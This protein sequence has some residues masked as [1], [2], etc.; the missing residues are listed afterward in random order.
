M[1]S[2]ASLRRGS[3]SGLQSA[4]SAC[5]DSRA[6]SIRRSAAAWPAVG[7][8]VVV[9]EPAFVEQVDLLAHPRGV[10]RA[11][12]GDRVG[13]VEVDALVGLDE[14]PGGPGRQVDAGCLD[15]ALDVRLR[16]LA[17]DQAGELAGQLAQRVAARRGREGL[18]DAGRLDRL[19][20]RALLDQPREQEGDREDHGGDEKH[21]RERVAERAGVGVAD[22][23]GQA[24]DG[25]G[26]R[27]RP[28]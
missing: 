10:D 9:D 27:A 15:R 8:L 23:R 19:A 6:V 16:A 12:V 5:R 17:A 22:R 28:R 21:G 7:E 11:V 20:Q 2:I 1:R 13:V 4:T 14:Q 18:A 24:L 26:V 25:R 3:S